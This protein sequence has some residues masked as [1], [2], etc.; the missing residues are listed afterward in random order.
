M[1]NVEKGTETGQ[2]VFAFSDVEAVMA[3]LN[4]L[5]GVVTLLNTSGKAGVDPADIKKLFLEAGLSEEEHAVGVMSLQRNRELFIQNDRVYGREWAEDQTAIR[6]AVM[7]DSQSMIIAAQR[8][9]IDQMEELLA[10]ALPMVED[11]EIERS[12]LYAAQIAS[13]EMRNDL[14]RR[15]GSLLQKENADD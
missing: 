5:Q 4:V 13:G 7:H 6:R 9:L 11:A 1:V 15:I 3:K 8:G 10:E 14:S 12:K 2:E